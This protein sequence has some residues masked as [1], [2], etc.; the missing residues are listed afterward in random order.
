MRLSGVLLWLIGWNRK[1][2]ITRAGKAWRGFKHVASV[3]GCLYV[4]LQF[5]PQVVFAHS[6]EAGGIRVYSMSPVPEHAKTLLGEIHAKLAASELYRPT[7]TF[8]VFVCNSRALYTLLAPGARDAFGVSMPVT[9]KIILADADLEGNV[10]MAFRPEWNKRSF[11]GVV[12]HECGHSLVRRRIDMF[13]SLRLPRWL[14]EGYSEY[15][16]GDSS[17]PQAEGDR[18]I[19]RGSD[20]GG[21]AFTYLVY[22]RM[23]EY[24]I[25][26]QGRRIEDLAAHPPDEN[27]VKQQ[28]R[29]W[30]QEGKRPGAST[31]P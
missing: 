12:T 25:D 1:K 10:A 6:L 8:N 2:P 18:Q 24:L 3:L 29:R 23:A 21:G 30:L 20:S 4:L 7:D 19:I 15:L 16:A 13:A 27:Q 28:M 11:T 14:S 9:G 5:F 17:Y 22:W 26:G 31:L